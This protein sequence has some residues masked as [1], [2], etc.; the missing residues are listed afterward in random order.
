[1]NDQIIGALYIGSILIPVIFATYVEHK[2]INSPRLNSIL[3]KIM[4]FCFFFPV[5]VI[6]YQLF[7]IGGVGAILFAIFFIIILVFLYFIFILANDL[8][9]DNSN[10]I[11]LQNK[12]NWKK[13]NTTQEQIPQDNKMY[14]LRRQ[15]QI[16]YKKNKQVYIY[17]SEHGWKKSLD[18]DQIISEIGARYERYIGYLYETNGYMVD[19]NGIVAGKKDDSVDIIAKKGKELILIQCKNVKNENTI[20]IRH[21]RQFNDKFG[22]IKAKNPHK[23]VMAYFYSTNNNLSEEARLRLQE[24]EIIHTI[25]PY[26]N[27][28]P[29]IKC[30]IGK[31]GSKIYHLP[32]IGMYDR[33]KIEINKGECYVN[34]VEEAEALGFR[35]V[36]W[37]N[38]KNI[39]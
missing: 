24:T 12:E 25:V 19:F 28:Y 15:E 21:I 37:A 7:S 11:N 36:I 16:H 31:E 27:N 38:Q 30:N 26:D 23:N 1:M 3:N 33:I 9:T 6:V 10:E 39:L 14:E 8:N 32:A 22:E 13:N 5:F 29:L 20:H 4:F 2:K 17:R 18:K 35:A 34:S